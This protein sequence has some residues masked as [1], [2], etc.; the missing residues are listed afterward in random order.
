M[1][2]ILV[3]S[4]VL[5]LRNVR[6]NS[7]LEAYEKVP[8]VFHSFSDFYATFTDGFFVDE[9]WNCRKRDDNQIG[10]KSL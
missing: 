2:S 9:V 8:L 5:P 3:T 1:Q 7:Q 6:I 10:P 4:C